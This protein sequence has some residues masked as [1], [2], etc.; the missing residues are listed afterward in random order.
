MNVTGQSAIITGGHS[1]MGFA[2]AQ[3]LRAQGA[4]V[5]I[6]GRRKERVEAKAE[7]IG[8]VGLACDISDPGAVDAA[9]DAAEAVNGTARILINAAA[10]GNMCGLLN[11]DGSAAPLDAI[12]DTVAVNLLGTLYIDRAFA[13]RLTALQPDE[14]QLRGEIGRA[15]V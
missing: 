4:K 1:G 15:H 7:L 9:L 3:A 14:D 6:I 10:I 5:A 8:A 12:R 11:S 13:S 2:A